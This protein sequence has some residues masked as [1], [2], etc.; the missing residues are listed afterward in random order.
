MN[1]FKVGQ[2]VFGFLGDIYDIQKNGTYH[3]IVSSR[4][5]AVSDCGEIVLLSD[6]RGYQMSARILF[7]SLDK[8]Q[9]YLDK[10]KVCVGDVV[11][12]IGHQIS[13]KGKKL[14]L[15]FGKNIPVTGI[16][17]KANKASVDVFCNNSETFRMNRGQCLRISKAG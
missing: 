5:C 6:G 2:E 4:V 1:M 7:E 16:V 12:G 8:A 3:Q 17:T 9:E 11:T 15:Y 14:K 10:S 13:S